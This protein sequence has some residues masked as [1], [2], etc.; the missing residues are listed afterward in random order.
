MSGKRQWINRSQPQTLVIADFLLY[1]T[2]AINLL[3]F[4]DRA[5]YLAALC[6]DGG[7]CASARL[8]DLLRLALPVAGVA[9]AY[10][11]ANEQKWAYRLGIAVAA[12]PLTARVLVSL[13]YQISPLNFDLI[14]LMFDV[15][16]FAL[17]VHPQSRDYQRIWFTG[18]PRRGP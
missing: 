14:S 11:I 1:F 18:G 10:G 3:F 7:S 6:G 5:I 17:L 13:R 2:G 4:G 15:A 9:A 12:A 16:L 8:V